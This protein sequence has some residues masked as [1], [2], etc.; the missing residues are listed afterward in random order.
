MLIKVCKRH[1]NCKCRWPPI[2]N[3]YVIQIHFN[4][5]HVLLTFA[6]L[7]NA[8]FF[9]F[10]YWAI[11]TWVLSHSADYHQLLSSLSFSFTYPPL[12]H[13]AIFYSLV[14]S[15][16]TYK[17]RT[18]L[19]FRVFL[20][21]F[22]LIWGSLSYTYMG[23]GWGL[24]ENMRFPMKRNVWFLINS[25]KFIRTKQFIH[26]TE[27]KDDLHKKFTYRPFMFISIV[28]LS[29]GSWCQ[30]KLLRMSWDQQNFRIP[31]TSQTNFK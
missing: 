11:W 8:K 28:M 30:S 5:H 15:Q 29:H 1:I 14:L 27:T 9:F 17:R 12:H 22:P 4:E 26:S 25:L 10:F 20:T 24:S 16:L 13:V 19:S 6:Y 2:L 31:K 18:I 3:L 21:F 7:T 23:Y